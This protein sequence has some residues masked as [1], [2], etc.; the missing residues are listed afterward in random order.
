[1][2]REVGIDADEWVTPFA[3]GAAVGLGHALYDNALNLVAAHPH[4]PESAEPVAYRGRLYARTV[5]CTG[6]GPEHGLIVADPRTGTILKR[7]AVPFA[8]GRL[9]GPISRPGEDGCD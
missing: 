6:T 9:G 2:V 3:G 4:L 1:M 7:R 5:T 8:I